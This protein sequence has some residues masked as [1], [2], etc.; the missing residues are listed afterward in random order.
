MRSIEFTVP[1]PPIP[2]ARPRLGRG[3][4]TYTP[5]RTVDAERRIRA[6]FASTGADPIEGA[7]HIKITCTF[8]PPASWSKKKQQAALD[9]QIQKTSKPDADNL[10]KTVCDAL[11]GMA[12]KDDAQITSMHVKKE[13]GQ[14]DKTEVKI[15][16]DVW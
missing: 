4:H 11:N 6:A 1:G 5:K 12:W 7:L 14:E 15:T 8:R 9:G 13:Y 3:G 16:E 10:A 2:K